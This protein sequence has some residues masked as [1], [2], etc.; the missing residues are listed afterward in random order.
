MREVIDSMVEEIAEIEN[1]EDFDPDQLVSDLP[2]FD[3]LQTLQN[4]G[5]FQASEAKDIA[6][7]MHEGCLLVMESG[8]MLEPKP[9]VKPL[10]EAKVVS[11]PVERSAAVMQAAPV[12]QS[13]PVSATPAPVQ[14]VAASA[15]VSAMVSDVPPTVTLK[16]GRSVQQAATPVQ[17]TPNPAPANLAPAN[18][19]GD[20]GAKDP[21]EMTPIEFYEQYLKEKNKMKESPSDPM[22]GMEESSQMMGAVGG[23]QKTDALNDLILDLDRITGK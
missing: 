14:K 22:S 17:S 7:S 3:D 8:V 13:A 11:L 15:Q 10:P 18:D 21:K 9:E 23:E 1:P 4:L 6:E 20:L 12:A 2:V 19:S 16:G 5:T